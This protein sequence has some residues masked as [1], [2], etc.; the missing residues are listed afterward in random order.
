[1]VPI[2]ERSRSK[3]LEA[4]KKR[5]RPPIY[6]SSQERYNRKLERDRL[7]QKNYRQRKN[8]K[9]QKIEEQNQ[10]LKSCLVAAN[11]SSAKEILEAKGHVAEELKKIRH[12]VTS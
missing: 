4:P 10:H 9:I 2:R 3:E 7:N 8:K 5:G 1:M 11:H 6:R 12:L